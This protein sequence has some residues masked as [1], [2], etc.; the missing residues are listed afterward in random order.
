MPSGGPKAKPKDV[1]C[2]A[3]SKGVSASSETVKVPVGCDGTTVAPFPEHPAR[4]TKRSE[5]RSVDAVARILKL[6]AGL[7][8]LVGRACERN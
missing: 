3:V 4:A 7:A 6:D 8:A 1:R 5:E 2:A